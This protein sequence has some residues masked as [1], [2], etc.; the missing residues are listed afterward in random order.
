MNEPV[1][2]V[3]GGQ[4]LREWRAKFPFH[5]YTLFVLQ[6]SPKVKR[7][8]KVSVY[9]TCV[10]PLVALISCKLAPINYTNH[11]EWVEIGIAASDAIRKL[12]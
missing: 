10:A 3:I 6:Q 5:R 8:R 7:L 4:R 11:T 1:E 2:F 9:G 12:C